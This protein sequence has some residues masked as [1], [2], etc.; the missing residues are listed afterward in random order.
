MSQNRPG[1]MRYTWKNNAKA[2]NI[3]QICIQMFFIDSEINVPGYLN[4]FSFERPKKA[5]ND[6]IE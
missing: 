5:M 1:T 4:S 3:M 2:N 6:T